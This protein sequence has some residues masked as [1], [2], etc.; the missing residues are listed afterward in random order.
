M[1][2]RSL[3]PGLRNKPSAVDHSGIAEGSGVD[4]WR[5]TSDEIGSQPRRG[6]SDAK[7]MTTEAGS[8]IKAR[9]GLYRRNHR[10]SVRGD[11]DHA[12]PS[13][14]NTHIAQDGIS[15]LEIGERLIEY[16]LVGHR[17]EHAHPLKGRG[18]IE[19]PISRPE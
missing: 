16:G 5:G 15:G 18:R 17:I 3:K 6:R 19:G 12:R 1:V 2:Q 7:A 8:E 4:E 14:R 10:Y 13:F 11:V 9:Q